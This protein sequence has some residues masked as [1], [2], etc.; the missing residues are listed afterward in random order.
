MN[1]LIVFT[2]SCTNIYMYPAIAICRSKQT[3]IIGG[4]YLCLLNATY[5]PP[6]PFYCLYLLATKYERIKNSD[7]LFNLSSLLI[8]FIRVI[9]TGKHITRVHNDCSVST[10]KAALRK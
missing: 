6:L 8:P 2:F 5:I 1:Y 4:A 3:Q 9:R 7:G 10:P